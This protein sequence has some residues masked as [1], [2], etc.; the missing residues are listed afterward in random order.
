MHICSLQELRD[1]NIF[2]I[3]GWHSNNVLL[4]EN[5]EIRKLLSAGSFRKNLLPCVID[6]TKVK[7]NSR[8]IK[9]PEELILQSRVKVHGTDGIRGVVSLERSVTG[10]NFIQLFARENKITPDF[11][12]NTAYAFSSLLLDTGVLKKGEMVLIG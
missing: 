5:S 1:R 8:L 2:F 6:L 4:T 9:E 10:R 12:R 3:D 11:I 7:E